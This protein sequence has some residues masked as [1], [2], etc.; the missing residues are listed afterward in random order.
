MDTQITSLIVE[1]K[2]GKGTTGS[3]TQ[4]LLF[5]RQVLWP[6]KPQRLIDPSKMFLYFS[7]IIFLQL[8]D[9]FILTFFFEFWLFFFYLDT[10]LEFKRFSSRIH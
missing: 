6:A 4:D 7:E 9:T 1:G 5:T 2:S 10:F 8:S 3:W